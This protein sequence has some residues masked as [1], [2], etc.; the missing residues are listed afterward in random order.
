M[1]EV[2]TVDDLQVEVRRSTRRR[3]VDFHWRT[4]LLPPDMVRYL[5]THELVHLHEPNHGPAF[6]E[7]LARVAPDYEEREAWLEKHGDEYSL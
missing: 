4:I 1:S 2:I 3:T 7:R 6:Y 5:I